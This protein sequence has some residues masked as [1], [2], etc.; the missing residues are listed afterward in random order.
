M[1]AIIFCPGYEVKLVNVPSLDHSTVGNAT[2][3]LTPLPSIR[4][5]GKVI[6]PKRNRVAGFMIEA[7]Y[8]ATWAHEFFGIADGLVCA[9]TVAS[10]RVSDEG[11]FSITVPDFAHDPSINSFR[12]KGVIKLTAREPS[13]GNMPYILERPDNSGRDVEI[14]IDE[15]YKNELILYARTRRG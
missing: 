5:S 11:S 10:A 9:F 1:K 12:E 15:E 6:L 13:T 3:E 8:Q 14:E 7:T 4:V 2:I